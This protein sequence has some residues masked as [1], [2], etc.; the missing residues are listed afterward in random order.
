MSWTSLR[1]S[2]WRNSIWLF[3]PI[4]HFLQKPYK[5]WVNSISFKSSGSVLYVWTRTSTWCSCHAV[6][7]NAVLCAPPPLP[8]V[9]SAVQQSGIP[10][11]S[12]CRDRDHVAPILGWLK[13]RNASE[14]YWSGR[15]GF[16][17]V[18]VLAYDEHAHGLPLSLCYRV[19]SH[20]VH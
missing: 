7:Q 10:C 6:I 9:L 19:Q 15:T 8:S 2:A 16:L 17:L 3:F 1:W 11:V 4:F 14:E 18:L 13:S 20:G 12:T 5:P